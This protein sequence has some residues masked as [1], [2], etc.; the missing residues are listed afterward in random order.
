MEFAVCYDNSAAIFAWSIWLDVT[1][2]LVIL[3]GFA[4]AMSGAIS[5][6]DTGTSRILPLEVHP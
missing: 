1:A 2:V 4:A 3:A 6:P 5:V